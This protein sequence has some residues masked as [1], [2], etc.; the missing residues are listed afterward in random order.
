MALDEYKTGAKCVGFLVCLLVH[1]GLLFDL[2][3]IKVI[4]HCQ[5]VTYDTAVPQAKAKARSQDR[6]VENLCAKLRTCSVRYRIS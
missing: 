3:D 6:C 1:F 5:F 4:L 2:F